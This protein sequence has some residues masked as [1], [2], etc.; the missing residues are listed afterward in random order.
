MARRRFTPSSTAAW[1]STPGRPTCDPISTAI[2]L[3]GAIP[4]T[5]TVVSTSANPRRAAS[6]ASAARSAG[7]SRRL[8]TWAWLAGRLRR[9]IF[10]SACIISRTSS[11]THHLDQARRGQPR[12]EAPH[13]GGLHVGVEERFGPAPAGT[14]PSPPRPPAGSRA[15]RAMKRSMESKS[16]S[17]RP[18]SSTIRPDS[19]RTLAGGSAGPPVRTR[20]A[21]GHSWIVVSLRTGCR[22]R[23]RALREPFPPSAMAGVYVCWVFLSWPGHL[24][25]A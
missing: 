2:A 17:A 7:W 20:P 8:V 18:S 11:S 14:G 1:V 5:P 13:L 15:W 24:G 3:R 9:R 4:A 6:A 10:R 25:D 12:E 21:S 19:T 22:A 23:S 16:L